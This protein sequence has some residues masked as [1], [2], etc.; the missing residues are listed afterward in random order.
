MEYISAA[1][2]NAQHGEV[3]EHVGE[4]KL[5][6]G[7]ATG[8]VGAY[9]L[10]LAAEPKYDMLGV[11]KPESAEEKAIKGK[12]ERAKKAGGKPVVKDGEKSLQE[13]RT[14]ALGAANGK[15][16]VA[17]YRLLLAHGTVERA[18]PTGEKTIAGGVELIETAKVPQLFPKDSKAKLVRTAMLNCHAG[19]CELVFEGTGAGGS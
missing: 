13:M 2:S 8:A 7:D 3:G 16:G 19:A 6:A 4:I 10:A 14:V 18:E 1:W 17:E 9:E 5:A 12:L 11:R 15:D